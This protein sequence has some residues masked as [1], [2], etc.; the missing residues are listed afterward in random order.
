MTGRTI[1]GEKGTV[2]RNPRRTPGRASPLALRGAAG[3]GVAID[4][5][6]TVLFP[7]RIREQRRRKGI[8]SLLMLA[9]R[10]PAIP[11]IR[12]SKIERG[13]IF[14]K[15]QELHQIAT[16]IGLDD[17]ARLLL[18]VEAADFS[19]A[20][21]AGS[22]GETGELNRE[23]E[24]LAMLLAAAFRAR[25]AGDPALTLARLQ[26]D[27]GLP[28]VIV[29]RIENAVK[30]FDRWNADTIASVCALLGVRDR[31]ALVDHLRTLH[32]KGALAEWLARIPGARER[33]RRTRDRIR[34]LRTELSQLPPLPME[35]DPAAPHLTFMASDPIR[36]DRLLTVLGVPA[37]DGAIDPFPG[38]QQVAPPPDTGPNAYALRMCRAS[39]GAAIPGH[40]V[41]IVDPDRTPVQGGLTVLREEKGLRVLTVTTDR[42]GRLYGMSSNP[43]REVALDAVPPADLAMVTAVL[44]V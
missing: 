43:E 23:T 14:A 17:P 24:E 33:E 30:P 20:L 13:E 38:P 27:H 39:L 2:S 7:N 21:W 44:F 28:A 8:E 40:A 36:P 41:L 16:V 22:R 35:T 4:P 25:R 12:L 42:D 15:A 37:G 3:I 1:G 6:R 26:G 5:Y 9:G 34:G 18:D 31:A 29:S 32:E 10:L 19:I 11:Y